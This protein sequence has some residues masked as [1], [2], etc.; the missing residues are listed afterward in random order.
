FN[1]AS[2]LRVN[3]TL[4]F[5]SEIQGAGKRNN[6]GR[7][8]TGGEVDGVIFGLSEEDRDQGFQVVGTEGN[9][10]PRRKGICRNHRSKWLG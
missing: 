5:F 4:A 10:N 8:D 2:G 7:A 9:V 1:F 6:N 3:P